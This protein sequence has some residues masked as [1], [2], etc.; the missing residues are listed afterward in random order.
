MP[1]SCCNFHAFPEHGFAN[2]QKN[3]DIMPAF[4]LFGVDFT[5]V[6]PGYGRGFQT[7]LPGARQVRLLYHNRDIFSAQ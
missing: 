5:C 2:L 3:R 4:A 6:L 7:A 1:L